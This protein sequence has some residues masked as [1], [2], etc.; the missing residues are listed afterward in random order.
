MSQ[1][2][3]L[4]W[5]RYEK[6][7]ILYYYNSNKIKG[8]NHTLT[9]YKRTQK[10]EIVYSGKSSIKSIERWSH[11]AYDVVD[12]LDEFD[13]KKI[14]YEKFGANKIQELKLARGNY[15]LLLGAYVRL[16]KLVHINRQSPIF[17][18]FS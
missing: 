1:P 16:Q 17:F 12:L 8:P 4:A 18:T 7:P 2:S 14:R 10:A 9:S 3:V 15:L 13:D 6:N 5:T 11:H